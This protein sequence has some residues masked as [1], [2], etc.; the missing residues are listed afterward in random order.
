M[1]E[2]SIRIGNKNEMMFLGKRI[3]WER[4]DRFG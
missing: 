1:L 3:T 4:L 2:T